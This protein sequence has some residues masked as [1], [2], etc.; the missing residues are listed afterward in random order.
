MFIAVLLPL[1]LSNLWAIQASAL[2]GGVGIG[3]FIDEVG[4]F[5]TQTNDYFFP[6]AHSLIYGFFCSPFLFTSISGSY[7]RKIPA[8][9]CTMSLKGWRTHW[10]AI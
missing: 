2:L 10:T 3:L 6:P 9:Q 7:V 5:I 1:V 4:K 8:T